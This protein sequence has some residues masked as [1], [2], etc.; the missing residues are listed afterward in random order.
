MV[1]GGLLHYDGTHLQV[2]VTVDG[3]RQPHQQVVPAQVLIT[4]S[5]HTRRHSPEVRPLQAGE[6]GEEILL[7][8]SEQNN[9]IYIHLLR[10]VIST[11]S[12]SW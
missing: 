5:G 9:I 2:L 8:M 10:L 1:L 4:T 6:E 7:K 3:G 12:C 11:L